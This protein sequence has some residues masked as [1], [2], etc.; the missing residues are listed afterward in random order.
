MS[1]NDRLE[2]LHRQSR[3]SFIQVG[4]MLAV[5]AAALAGVLFYARHA[6][7]QRETATRAVQQMEPLSDLRA[8]ARSL[9]VEAG[10]LEHDYA[11]LAARTSQDDP[12]QTTD[13]RKTFDVKLNE[14]TPIGNRYSLLVDSI[15][16]DR[17]HLK[18]YRENDFVGDRYLQN[19]K[20]GYFYETEDV[21]CSIN[22]AGTNADMRSVQVDTFCETKDPRWSHPD[23]EPPS[24]GSLPPGT[25]FPTSPRSGLPGLAAGPGEVR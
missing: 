5:L 19:G 2:E 20:D 23:P 13:N 14:M 10:K 16:P 24:D 9:D 8:E 7:V 3:K 17:V 22:L 21:A 11:N 4:I 6:A 25:R 1:G 12:P 18:V 15:T